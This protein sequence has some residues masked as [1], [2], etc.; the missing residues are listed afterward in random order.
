MKLPLSWLRDYVALDMPVAELVHR[1]SVSAAEVNSVEPRGPV[2]ENGN[3]ALFLIA[4]VVEAGKHPNADRLQL[5]RVDVGEAEP[6]QIVCG[7]WNFGTGA[8]VAVALPGARLP[9]AEQ[10]LGEAKLRGELSRGMILSEREL[11]LGADH[12]GILV[13][14][15]TEPGTPLADVLPLA[16]AIM[17]VEP[18][19]NRVDLLS[20]YGLA[21]E[22]AA[23]F[24]L[25]LALPPG[26]DPETGGTERV[27]IAIDDL[28]GCP[29]YIGRTFSGVTVAPSPPWLRARI[30]AAGMRPIS[31]VV[32]VTN[33]VMLALGNP[34]HAFDRSTLA[35]DRILVRRAHAGETLRTLD[36]TERRLDGDDLVIADGRQAVALAGIM[37]GEETEVRDATTE[38]LLEAANFEPVGLLRSSERLKLRTE[39]SNRWEKG[40][41]PHLAPQA[42]ALATELLVEI[43]GASWTGHADIHG[44][45]P[46]RMSIRLRAG[47]ADALIGLKTPP[48]EQ[49][50]I[51]E[52]FGFEAEDDRVTVPTWRARDV[53]REVDLVEEIA[54]VRLDEVPFTLPRRSEMFGSLTPVQRFRRRIEDVLVGLGLAEIY[55]PSLVPTVAEPGGLTL[56]DP[57]GNQATL[58][59]TLLHGLVETARRNAAVDNEGLA[60]FEIARVYLP[61]AN[62]LPDEQ[63]R[64]AA[65]VEG[66]FA[67]AKGVVEALYGALKIELAVE[68]TT[69]SFLYPGRAASLD[70]GWLG[71]LHP[72]LLEGRWGAVE[73]DLDLLCEGSRDPVQYE[74]VLTFP[75]V[76]HD[77]AFVV[78]AALPAETLFG[79]AREAAGP[80]LREVRFLSDFREPPI[81]AGKKSLAFRAEFRSPERTLTDDDVVPLRERIVTVL[82][83]R[84]GAELRA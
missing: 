15:E 25:E 9:G 64:V 8:T 55:T 5:C 51:L 11:E 2:D 47:R 46:E 49:R 20:V 82:G 35:D 69:R 79:A 71:E 16:D 66:G 31:N 68:P 3:H 33:Y 41:D 19:G 22:V 76:K 81:P 18:T 77:F 21:R 10:P 58:R 45:L 74:D 44:A 24:R 7:A 84:F 61:R 72:E 70:A 78:D 57:V 53:T 80:E 62:D 32:D 36:G 63:V 50:A 56:P 37:G 75:P 38:I 4:R 30:S 54:R 1:L 73:L 26:R 43:C 48:E 29:R 59:T 42:A 52:R 23:L 60:F 17:D 27:E 12:G 14:P 6:R 67:R 28:A 34:V 39:G 65:L 83:E 40:V 13:L